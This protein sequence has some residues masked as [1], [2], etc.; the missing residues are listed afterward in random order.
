MADTSDAQDKRDNA[1]AEFFEALADLGRVVKPAA[2]MA[3]KPYTEAVG[4]K[5]R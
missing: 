3:A 4:A 1:I 5:R 2:L